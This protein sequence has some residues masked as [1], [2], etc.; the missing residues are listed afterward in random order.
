MSDTTRVGLSIAFGFLMGQFLNSA[1]QPVQTRL[2]YGL[3]GAV[4]IVIM[5]FAITWLV[6]EKPEVKDKEKV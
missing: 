4:V 2:A 5:T 3:V 1:A 6:Q